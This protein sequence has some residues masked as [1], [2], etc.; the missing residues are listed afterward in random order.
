M[1]F[2]KSETNLPKLTAFQFKEAVLFIKWEI[3]QYHT[4]HVGYT[5]SC[6]VIKH[7]GL[8]PHL[9]KSVILDHFNSM[10]P[11]CITEINSW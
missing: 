10:G 11:H 1:H 6:A 4:A 2:K 9:N 8:G 7:F 5:H 3:R